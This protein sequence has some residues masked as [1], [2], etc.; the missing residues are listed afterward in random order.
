M[1]ECILNGEKTTLPRPACSV[2]VAL[3][4]WGYHADQV[5]VAVNQVF[6]PRSHY[7]SAQVSVGDAVEVVAPMQGG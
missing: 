7:A 6:V 5:A 2:Y 4:H 3:Q 1:A